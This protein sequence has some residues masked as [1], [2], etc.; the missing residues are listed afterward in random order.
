MLKAVTLL[1]DQIRIINLFAQCVNTTPR[2][3]R[4]WQIIS[5]DTREKNHLNVVIAPKS[6]VNW[7]R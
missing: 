6:L 7:Q 2:C 1:K 3:L 5:G 4:L